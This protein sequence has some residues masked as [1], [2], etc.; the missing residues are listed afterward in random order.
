M[1]VQN[2]TLDTAHGQY[3]LTL[4]ST[5]NVF[6]AS[7]GFTATANWSGSGGPS[8]TFTGGAS[9]GGI[10]ADILE[11]N[12]TF[13][14]NP[15]DAAVD[16]SGSLQIP[17]LSSP[18]LAVNASID[19]NQDLTGIPGLPSLNDLLNLIKEGARGP[20]ERGGEGMALVRRLHVGRHRPGL[21]QLA[22]G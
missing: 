10:L 14:V 15:G 19:G 9:I 11:G 17:G 12:A 8:F 6:V 21:E 5:V 13:T 22:A 1:K 2:A 20:R 7:V 16:F 3:S 18:K 4:T